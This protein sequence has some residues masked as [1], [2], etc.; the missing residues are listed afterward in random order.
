MKAALLIAYGLAAFA[1]GVWSRPAL[2]SENFAFW[3]FVVA[4]IFG[5]AAWWSK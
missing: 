2:K 5:V 4:M 1:C 3:A